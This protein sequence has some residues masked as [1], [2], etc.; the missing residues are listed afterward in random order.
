MK[1][2]RFEQSKRLINDLKNHG[3]Q[4]VIFSDEKTFSVDPLVN[5]KNNCMVSFGQDISELRNV[6][7]TKHPISVMLLGV[8]ASNGVKIPPVWF[9]RGYRLN[10]AA[11][12][13]VLVTK[14]LPWVRKI[15]RNANYVFQQDGAPA[16]T[17]KTVQEWLGSNMN[18]WSKDFWSPRSPDLNPLDYSVRTHIESK[19]CKVHH[20]SVEELKYSVNRSWTTMRKDYI[21]KVCK[22]FRPRLS[23]VIAAEGDQIEK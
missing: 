1:Q 10:A 6:F 22:D 18:F 17:A 12:K 2:K 16:H 20:N 9:P 21:R 5:K 7:T 11:Y 23:R 8:V 4:V 15:T 3:N 13:Y 14:I 19:A